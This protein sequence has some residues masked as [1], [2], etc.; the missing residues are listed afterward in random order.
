M[1]LYYQVR[2]PSEAG[3]NVEEDPTGNRSLW[4]RGVLNGASQK[5]SGCL[6]CGGQVD[7]C[8]AG[9]KWI[10][11]MRGTSGY[12]QCGGQ[13]DTCNAGDKWIPAMLGT[14]GYL[15]CWGQVDTCN[16]GGTSGIPAMRG[17]MHFRPTPF[18]H[19]CLCMKLV[20]CEVVLVQTVT[21]P[22]SCVTC[23]TPWQV[24]GLGLSSFVGSGVDA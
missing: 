22:I 13:V 23:V 2:L 20:L 5:A 14:S 15:Q 24:T 9:D 21:G 18:A 10:P 16:A 4:D 19:M 12:L 17:T 8:N 7:T 1:R 6:Q 11:A 3:D